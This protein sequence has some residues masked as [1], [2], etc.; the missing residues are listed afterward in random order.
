[1]SSLDTDAF[2]ARAKARVDAA[3]EAALPD[4]ESE[5][6]QV[7][8]A[9]R[10]AVLGD[11]K[12]VRPLFTLA[13]AHFCGEE[14]GKLLDAAC[15]VEFVHAASLILDD[16]PCMDDAAERRG[17]PCTHVRFG[18][19]AALL[20]AMSLLARAYERTARNAESLG[21]PER[22]AEAVRV[23]SDTIGPGGL[24][25]GQ[26]LDLQ[27]DGP[28]SA[29]EAIET[30]HAH[31]AGTL[32]LAAL[33]LPAV[34][35]ALPPAETAALETFGRHVGLAFQMIDDCHDNA[36]PAEDAGKHTTVSLLGEV[37]ARARAEAL[38][39]DAMAALEPYAERAEFL[40]GLA[41]YVHASASR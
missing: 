6:R 40:R 4:P 20:A 28:S 3:L 39:Q 29:P 14:P 41:E 1:M 9:M 13:A 25:Y 26:S 31:K 19:A 27:L 15:A 24:V 2:L 22:S 37:G 23:L 34:L 5:P 7:H 21:V 32:F 12:R 33:R 30:V 35:L 10:H 11:G 8:E 38:I 36:C 18:T 16:L 17:Q